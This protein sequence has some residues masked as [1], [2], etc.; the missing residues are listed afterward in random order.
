MIGDATF[1]AA[2][3][4]AV[5][6]AEKR[7]DA[8]I[9]VVAAER[10]GTYRDVSMGWAAAGS[11]VVLALMIVAP[12]DLHP[13][14]VLLELAIAFPVLTWM[15]GHR[16]FLRRVVSAERQ[17]AQV[18]AAAESEFVR[19]AVHGTP[20]HTGVLVY[21]SALEGRVEV[22]CDLLLA[23]RVAPGELAAA[24]GALVADDLDRFVKGIDGLA[25][26][27]ARIAPHLP[28]SDQADLP[29]APRMRT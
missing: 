28:D 29:N 4:D 8:E 21:V 5:G 20:R 18:R 23:G 12:V 10:S 17:S 7:T 3:E 9:V 26:L 13:I 14:G 11:L 19:E 27:F 22:I 6:R 1:A 25:D 15:A 24:T 16:A 2:V